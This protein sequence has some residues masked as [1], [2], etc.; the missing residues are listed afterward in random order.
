MWNT[1]VQSISQS[2]KLEFRCYCVGLQLSAVTPYIFLGND[3]PQ[4]S[5][6]AFV[7]KTKLRL[8]ATSY[9]MQQA[10]CNI[11]YHNCN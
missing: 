1:E 8:Q 9:N 11:P 5:S 3:S 7:K 4:R 2:R 10:T 6:E